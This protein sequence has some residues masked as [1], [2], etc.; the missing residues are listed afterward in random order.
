M[1][2]PATFWIATQIVDHHIMNDYIKYGLSNH[3][4]DFMI[5]QVSPLQV[6]RDEDNLSEQEGASSPVSFL[7]LLSSFLWNFHVSWMLNNCV[8]RPSLLKKILRTT[9]WRLTMERPASIVNFGTQE[10]NAKRERAAALSTTTT[11]STGDGNVLE[12]S[13]ARLMGLTIAVMN[14]L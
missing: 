8:W 5:I 9:W 4:W 11:D 6:H 14:E 2:L 7:L 1:N 10:R 3:C 12:A 13:L